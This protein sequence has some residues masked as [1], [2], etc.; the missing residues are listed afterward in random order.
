MTRDDPSTSER[1]ATTEDAADTEAVD[2]ESA[3]GVRFDRRNC[4]RLLAVGAVHVGYNRP[5]YLATR[6]G[7]T[8]QAETLDQIARAL[9]GLATGNSA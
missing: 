3:R 7:I 1:T 6:H 5:N 8:G 9:R 4:L 2:T